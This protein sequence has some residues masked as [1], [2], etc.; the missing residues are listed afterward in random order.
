MD[1]VLGEPSEL[2][3]VVLAGQPQLHAL[4]ADSETEEQLEVYCKTVT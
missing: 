2:D 4:R 3:E 1:A